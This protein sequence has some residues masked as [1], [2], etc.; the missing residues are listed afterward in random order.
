ML[1][2]AYCAERQPRFDAGRIFRIFRDLI[3]RGRFRRGSWRVKNFE[4]AARSEWEST[5]P[6]TPDLPEATRR[7][8]L[9]RLCPHYAW[10][11][12][13][14]VNYAGLLRSTSMGTS[15]LSA[16]AVL[17]PIIG[18]ILRFSFRMEIGYKIPTWLELGLIVA[19]LSI[20][21][22]GQRRRW[23]ERWLNYRQLAELLRQYCYL[24]PLGCPLPSPRPPAHTGSNP[25]RSWVDGMFRV[26][27]RDLGLAPANARPRYLL[28]IGG[29]MDKIL[30]GQI[31]YHKTNHK[32]MH[33][34]S[35][36][37]HLIGTSLFVITLLAC[38]AHLVPLPISKEDSPWLVSWLVL[39][40]VVPPA[41]GAAFYAIANQGEFERSADRS[42]AMTDEL[43]SLRANDLDE[44]I[45]SVPEGSAAL[46]RAAQ[47]IAATM[48][49]ETMDWSFVF[50]YR[51]LNLPG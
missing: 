13:L 44:A 2:Q 36:R 43:E 39:L 40:A 50:R 20:T 14:S 26:I 1:S 18:Y 41:L 6:K 11:D 7:Y 47:R 15:L 51:K 5:I 31:D 33:K 35:H 45:K 25:H 9:D 46:R 38:V 12:G 19:I 8:L 23:H 22:H 17:V 24:A 27:A 16:C 10:A 49:A 42:S 30:A 32:I 21:F 48:I 4:A 37:V 28:A 29:M 34:L 3:A